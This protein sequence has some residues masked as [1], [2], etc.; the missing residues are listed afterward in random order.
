[1]KKVLSEWGIRDIFLVRTYPLKE[2]F[3]KLGIALP[4]HRFP[5]KKLCR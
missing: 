3:H 5:E 1:S 2:K 4:E